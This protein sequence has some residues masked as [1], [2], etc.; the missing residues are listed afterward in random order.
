MPTREPTASRLWPPPSHEG[1]QRREAHPTRFAPLAPFASSREPPWPQSQEVGR[2]NHRKSQKDTVPIRRSRRTD[3]PPADDEPDRQTLAERVGI[4]IGIGIGIES[5]RGRTG[6]DPDAPAQLRVPIRGSRPGGPADDSP[7]RERWVPSPM[8]TQPRQGRQN[9]F[10]HTNTNIRSLLQRPKMPRSTN[11][12]SRKASKPPRSTSSP[13]WNPAP[14]TGLKSVRSH[15]TSHVFAERLPH[16][17]ALLRG[18]AASRL[19]GFAAS[20]EPSLP[21]NE[22]SRDER[23]ARTGGCT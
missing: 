23:E 13:F 19:R 16:R 20:R 3:T 22:I 5:S 14:A 1:P 18:F 8:N 2:K 9:P 15:F 7:A 6:F 21:W 4:G 17:P 12:I 11:Q 10:P